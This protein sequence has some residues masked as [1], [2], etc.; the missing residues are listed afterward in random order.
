MIVLSLFDGISCGQVALE[1][2]GIKVDTYYASEIDK[3]AIQTTQKNYPKTIQIG[4]VNGIDF[5]TYRGK[6]NL[7]M[8]GSPCQGFSF[9]GKQL[10]FN[11][12]RSK[13]FFEFVRLLEKT[14]PKYFLLENVKMKKEYQ[15]IIT[16]HLGVN[17][18]I[19]NSSW[20]SAQD[21]K[22]LYWTNMPIMPIINKNEDTVEDILEDEVDIKY[23]I[24]PKRAVVILENEVK[25][26]KIGYIGTDSQGNR[27]YRIHNKSVCLVGEAGGLG[28]KTGLY[29]LPCLTPDRENQRQMGRRF[30]PPH[31]KFYT[32]TALDKHGVLT[33]NFIRKLTP[34]ECER[35][36]TLPDN[37]TYGLSDNQRYKLLGN[38]WTV[39]VIAHILS[40]IK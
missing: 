2:A 37:Y 27:I 40:Y 30:K 16:K 5:T 24:E 23:C 32:L 11:D 25:R 38:G 9:A 1:R 15:D 29:A 39:N 8:G 35:L 33:N 19:I 13:L 34:I 14:Q 4:D 28:A 21:R 12:S 20:F 10:N 26:R 3:Y 6:I 31:S 22:R 36:Q 7:L 17:P 18:V